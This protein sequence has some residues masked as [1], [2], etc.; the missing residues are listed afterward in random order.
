M[1]KLYG[2]V[3]YPVA[4]SLSPVFQQAAMESLG[5][6]AAYVPFQVPPEKIDAALKAMEILG[7]EGFN[8]TIPHKESVSKLIPEKDH[9]STIVGA[10]NTV[11]RRSEGWFGANT[12]VPGFREA[13]RL[14]VHRKVRE[15]LF[16][17][18]VL[19]AGGS[20]RSVIFALREAGFGKLTIANRSPERARSLLASLF[21][22]EEGKDVSILSLEELSERGTGECDVL[23]NALSREAF[24]ESFPVLD[25]VDCSGVKGF[26]DLSYRSD[27]LPTPFLEAGLRLGIPVEDGL[28]M[29]L[30]QGALSFELWTGLPAPR[31]VMA[32]ALQRKL[33]RPLSFVS[34]NK[35]A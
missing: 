12:D 28:G 26:L 1:K 10:V 13:F 8:V 22:G 19:G 4:H 18:V 30:E 23:I 9:V 21:P 35:G 15:T 7:V 16:H 20:A 3:G 27:G 17:P 31:N 34:D 6:D 24:P 32:E 5:I 29:L 11:T 14:F 33:G 2:V 25:R